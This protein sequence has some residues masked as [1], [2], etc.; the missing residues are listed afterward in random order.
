MV[1]ESTKCIKQRVLINSQPFSSDKTLPFVSDKQYS[2]ILFTTANHWSSCWATGTLFISSL[3]SG[4]SANECN[5][6][7]EQ[8]NGDS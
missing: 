8:L 4:S 5:W 6:R 3:Q 7:R 1:L 2:I